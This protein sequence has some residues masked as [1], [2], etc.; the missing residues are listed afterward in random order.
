MPCQI[1][2]CDFCIYDNDAVDMAI[3]ISPQY[4]EDIDI[5]DSIY[6]YADAVYDDIGWNVGIVGI[7]DANNQYYSIKDI[8]DELRNNNPIKAELIV[9]ED[10]GQI[11]N[12]SDPLTKRYPYCWGAE[13]GQLF[14]A[15]DRAV[16]FLM[17]N[18]DNS[19]E[20]KKSQLIGS[21]NK[22]SIDRNKQHIDD[23]YAFIS[24][25]EVIF[26]HEIAV[27][28][29]EIPKIGNVHLFEDADRTTLESVLY[30]ECKM[31][32]ASG[33]SHP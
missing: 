31:F 11:W 25:E 8:I 19:Y 2:T 23:V 18:N 4:K 28:E 1:P 6:T 10:I 17:P 9:G 33:H 3:F 29:G 26:D 30:N 12:R 16:A 24:K 14:H 22:F 5:V 7:D 15:P 20:T 21:F 32:V 27:I 13:E